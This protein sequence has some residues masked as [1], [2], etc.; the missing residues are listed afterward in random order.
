M[1][2]KLKIITPQGIFL[3]DIVDVVTLKTTEG[4]LSILAQHIPL[5]ANLEVAMMSFKKAN[6]ETKL[7]LS[8]GLLYSTRNEVKIL[9][10][11]IE[12]EQTAKDNL[13]QLVKNRQTK[14]T[15]V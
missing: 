11:G 5:V 8:A 9:T 6:Q 4:Y 7:L 2:L 3:D 1:A 12:Y 15:D 14:I 13:S 10:D